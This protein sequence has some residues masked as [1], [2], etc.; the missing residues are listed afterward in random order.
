[1]IRLHS[2]TASPLQQKTAEASIYG[3]D[4]HINMRSKGTRKQIVTMNVAKQKIFGNQ[5]NSVQG[6]LSYCH[7]F[8]YIPSPYVHF[9][10]DLLNVNRDGYY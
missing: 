7:F 6:H 5:G 3:N 10:V 4:E 1:M 2:V 9:S 8:D